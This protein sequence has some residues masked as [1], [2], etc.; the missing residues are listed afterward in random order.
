MPVSIGGVELLCNN[1]CSS[2][3][4]PKYGEVNIGFDLKHATLFT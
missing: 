3:P 1:G 2:P 4:R